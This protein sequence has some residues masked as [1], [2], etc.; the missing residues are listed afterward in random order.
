MERN[1]LVGPVGL[2]LRYPFYARVDLNRM[3]ANEESLGRKW[4]IRM[5]KA[6]F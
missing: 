2:L 6:T 1:A 5:T 3:I 4:G